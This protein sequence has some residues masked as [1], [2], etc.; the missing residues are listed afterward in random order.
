MAG[1]RPA[2]GGVLETMA[3]FYK[4]RQR[5]VANF[6][7]QAEAAAHEAYGEATRAGRDLRLRTQGEVNRFGARLIRDE[8]PQAKGPLPIPRGVVSNQATRSAPRRGGSPA[9]SALNRSPVTK[10]IAGDLAQLVGNGAGVVRG[11]A[12]AVEGLV[13]GMGFL[14]RLV[15]PLDALLSPPGES[16]SAQLAGAVSRGVDYVKDG[17]ADP[18]RVV[19]DVQ[20]KA[21][22]MRVDLD[23]G[24]T[25]IAPTVEEEVRRR[26]NI[27]MNQ[28]ELAFDVGSFVVGGPI[29]KS[30]EGLGA[31]SKAS[32]AGKYIAQGLRPAKAA[33]L[34]EP[35]PTS[36]MGHHF[37][38]RR[39]GLPSSYSDSVF[40][41]L[42]PKGITRGDMYELHFEVDP[43]FNHARLPARVGGGSWNGR[44]LGLEKYGLAGRLWHGSPAPLKARVGG[45][46][47]SVGGVVHDVTDEE[48]S[49]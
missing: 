30:V 10:E 39:I 21:H 23:P 26:L 46:G 43:S 8:K 47:A 14:G 31:A 42:K 22:Q 32:R 48:D 36:G 5:E 4:R 38:P 12:H 13:D 1:Y 25:A 34:A 37:G 45:L 19:R 6:G 28:G 40:N 16:A 24:A 3:D 35:Y 44:A 20:N 33:Y 29:A 11:G 9:G 15:N 41:V 27:G 49:W 2:R 7:Q 17:V 18:S